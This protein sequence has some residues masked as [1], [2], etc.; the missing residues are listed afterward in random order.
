MN[1]KKIIAGMLCTA[2]LPAT[3]FAY[4]QMWVDKNANVPKYKKLVIFPL[5]TKGNEYEYLLSDNERS[6]IYKMNDYLDKKFVRKLKY[7]TVDLG[8]PLAENNQIRADADKY[9]PLYEHF[10]NEAARG[11]AVED[12]TMADAYLVPIIRGNRVEEHISPATY[13][14]VQMRSDSICAWRSAI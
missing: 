1:I 2:M 7:V 13:V 4:G 5:A 11:K 14:N 9:K 12:I 3:A 10:P 8:S 6:E